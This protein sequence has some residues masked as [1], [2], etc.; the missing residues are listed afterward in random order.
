MYLGPRVLPVYDSS[1]GSSH[2]SA[3]SCS[4]Y[5]GARVSRPRGWFIHVA[6][7]GHEV[8]PSGSSQGEVTT[9]TLARMATWGGSSGQ[10]WPCWPPL[11]ACFDF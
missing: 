10:K 5:L 7:H 3:Y 11:Y 9:S 1:P 2:P 4:F 8:I 6:P